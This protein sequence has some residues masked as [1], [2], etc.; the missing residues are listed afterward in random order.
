MGE[1]I[2]ELAQELA[3]VSRLVEDD[4]VATTL[5]RFVT[6]VVQTVPGCEEA[7][8][9]VLTGGI[10]EIVARH[11]RTTDPLVE[12]A[13]ATLA[14]ELIKIGS[15]LHDT[16]TYDEPHRIGDLAS[17]HRWP[18]FAAAA[19]NA[20]YRSCLLL[21]LPASDSSGAFTLF[22]DKPDAFGSTS[23]DVVLL[24][25]LNAGVAFDNVQLFNDSRTLIEQLRT[26]LAT[27]TVIGQAV[28]LLMHRYGITSSVAFDV[29][30]RCS[31]DA[32]VKLRQV[33]LD[34]VEAQNVGQL[35]PALRKYGLH[36][37]GG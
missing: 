31:Q 20:G 14:E 11:H 25:A 35:A 5:G 7:A 15:P 30:K 8:I 6:R 33:S 19:I 3:E 28:G 37:D 4:D 23:Y 22:S 12:P 9:T 21:P 27:R 17:D 32:N 13:R 34:L 36:S 16:L 29:L 10:A 2:L 18:A 26:A 1:G 24:F